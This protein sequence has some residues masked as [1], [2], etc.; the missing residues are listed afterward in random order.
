MVARAQRLINLEKPVLVLITEVKQRWARIVLL[1][2]A[3][4][5][6][7][8]STFFLSF[9]YFELSSSRSSSLGD[10]MLTVVCFFPSLYQQEQTGDWTAIYRPDETY[11]FKSMR[12]SSKSTWSFSNLSELSDFMLRLVWFNPPKVNGAVA[13]RS[14][15]AVIKKR[16]NLQQLTN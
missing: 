13:L 7:I 4:V 11:I 1:E 10:P 14:F 5:S 12:S 16:K 6:P 8:S 3:L 9:L 2:S 15:L